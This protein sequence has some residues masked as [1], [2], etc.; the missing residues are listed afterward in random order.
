MFP[1]LG[2]ITSRVKAIY[3]EKSF[4][5]STSSIPEQTTFGILLDRTNFYA[6]AGG[7]EHDTGSI[8]IDD[9]AEYEV[10]NV[11]VFNGYV[12]HIGYLKY[13]ELKIDDEVIASYDEVS[14]TSR[15]LDFQL[16]T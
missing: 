9:V 11:Q 14:Y 3:H 15:I 1:V 4:L 7:Q 6:E 10:T 2:H 8:T 5:S 16:R 13:G 12:L